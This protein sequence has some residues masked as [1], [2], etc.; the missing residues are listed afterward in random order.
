MHVLFE[1]VIVVKLRFV[2]TTVD[3][4]QSEFVLQVAYE[5]FFKIVIILFEKSFYDFE[6]KSWYNVSVYYQYL[7]LFRL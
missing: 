7:N 1:H 6:M 5:K 2:P 4:G 3:Q